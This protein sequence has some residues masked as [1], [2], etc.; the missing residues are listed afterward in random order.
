MAAAAEDSS[1]YG[2]DVSFPMHHMTQKKE[3]HSTNDNAWLQ[4]Q[5][6]Q[7]STPSSLP[8]GTEPERYQQF[9]EGCVNY[10]NNQNNKEERCWINER[11]RIR[12]NLRQPAAVYNYTQLGFAKM[13]IPINLMRALTEL[14]NQNQNQKR[15]ERWAPGNIYTNNWLAPTYI[16]NVEDTGLKGGGPH[17]RKWIVEQVREVLEEWTGQHLAETRL[18]GIRIYQNQSILSPHVDPLPLVSSVILNIDQDVDEPWPLEVIGLYGMAHNI[19]MQPGDMILYESHSI[20]HGRPFPL[21]GANLFAHFEPIGPIDGPATTVHGSHTPPSYIIRNTFLEF[22]WKRNLPQG[23]HSIFSGH[24]RRLQLE[25]P[26]Y[27]EMC[28]SKRT[29]IASFALYGGIP[30][31]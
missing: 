9:M 27:I 19:T 17:W 18:Y 24:H 26:F 12:L 28:N 3:F 6:Q 10:Y 4:Q 7:A 16:L 11:E 21:L 8:L 20:I 15:L 23:Q 14:W 5:Q 31:C 30:T 29:P 1:S 2:V 25:V 22:D 13:Q